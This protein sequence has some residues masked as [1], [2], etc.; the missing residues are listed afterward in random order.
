MSKIKKAKPIRNPVKIY[1][2][3]S[4]ILLGVAAVVMTVSVNNKEF[5]ELYSTTI[6]RVFR[7]V[8]SAV[9]GIFPFSVIELLLFLLPIALVLGVVMMIKYINLEALIRT[10][11]VLLGTL[12]SVIFI[13]VNTFGTCYFRLSVDENMDIEKKPLTKQQLYD[14]ALMLKNQ[15]EKA[16]ENV[17]FDE[18]GAS[19]NPHNHRETARLINKGYE[20]L[21]SKYDFISNVPFGY[22]TLVVSP[23]MTYTHISGVYMPLTGEAN[24]NTNYPQYVTAFTAA[25]EMAHQRGIASEDEANFVAFLALMETGDDYLE[26]AALMSMY[27]YFLDAALKYETQIYND[28]VEQTDIKLIGEMYAYYEFFKKYSNSKASEV[29]DNVNDAYLKTMGDEDGVQS[30]GNVVELY[31]GYVNSK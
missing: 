15:A 31:Y 26:Y 27:D 21:S 5:A 25:H 4:C 6:G 12:F 20:K 18:K 3:T 19:V 16:S 10:L 14:T 22:K 30:Y 24:V 7:T 11:L 2:A 8:L 28:L 13:F 9:T 1:F 17:T 29:A 23:V